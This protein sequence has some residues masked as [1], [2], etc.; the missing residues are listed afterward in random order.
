MHFPLNDS[1]LHPNLERVWQLCLQILKHLILWRILILC[2]SFHFLCFW[3]WMNVKTSLSI[4]ASCSLTALCKLYMSVFLSEFLSSIFHIIK[5]F[6]YSVFSE[7]LWTIELVKCQWHFS[8]I[9]QISSRFFF[10]LCYPYFIASSFSLIIS[11]SFQ[12][13]SYGFRFL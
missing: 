13:G 10:S 5:P 11:Y 1:C 12:F 9:S 4:A 3:N 6:F 8:L 2:H 7:F